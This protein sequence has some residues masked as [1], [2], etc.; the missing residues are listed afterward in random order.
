MKFVISIIAIMASMAIHS[1]PIRIFYEEDSH[2]AEVVRE[3]FIE[4]YQIP[5]E[6]FTLSKTSDCDRTKG[7]N[8]LDL[9]LKN[10]GD[11]IVVSVDRRFISDTLR[12][13]QTP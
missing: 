8:K 5:T 11:L 12:I 9:C 10:N 6:L 4:N 1:E 2:N 13:F 7:N 3:I